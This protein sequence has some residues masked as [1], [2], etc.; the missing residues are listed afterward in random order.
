MAKADLSPG[1]TGL[2][3]FILLVFVLLS[4]CRS[5]PDRPAQVP[6]KPVTV[7]AGTI[8]GPP[9]KLT[10]F[11]AM[12][13][14]V[15][16]NNKTAAR[17]LLDEGSF[18]VNKTLDATSGWTL[19][20]LAAQYDRPEIGGMLLQHGAKINA[21]NAGGRTPLGIA[22]SHQHPQ[23]AEVLRKAGGTE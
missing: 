4:A 19:L 1:T 5:E 14:S 12:V 6:A 18:D 15:I 7:Q 16:V 11:D 3:P 17:D 23:M 13:H 10:G 9:D 8:D 20:H 22:L 21:R 2:R